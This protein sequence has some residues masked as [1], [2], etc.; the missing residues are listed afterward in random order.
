MPITAA[1]AD[2]LIGVVVEQGESAM[3]AEM[4]IPDCDLDEEHLAV[5][6]ARESA[7]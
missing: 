3:A 2:E 1:I 6:V 4:E 7:R 5:S